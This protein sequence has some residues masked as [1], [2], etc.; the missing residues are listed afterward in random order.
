MGSSDELLLLRLGLIAVLLLFLIAVA[1]VL[2]SGLAPGGPRVQRP[3]PARPRAR[4]VVVAP[5]LTGL[6]VGSDFELI[7]ETSLGR[8]ANSGIVLSDPSVSGR[9]ALLQRTDRGWL[10]RDLG[11]TNGTEV[12]GRPSGTRGLLLRDGEQLTI[13][14]VRF[15]FYA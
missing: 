6:A 5:A 12:A 11:S 15:R 7:G 14:S 3:A 8:D 9:H 10:V 13:G 4:L 1:L 2:R